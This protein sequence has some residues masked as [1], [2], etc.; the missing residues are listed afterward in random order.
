MVADERESCGRQAA[1]SFPLTFIIYA[2]KYV[3]MSVGVCVCVVALRAC[4][5]NIKLDCQ[6]AALLMCLQCS[7]ENLQKDRN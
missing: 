5:L 4:K 7:G 1:A 2:G 6:Y 3:C